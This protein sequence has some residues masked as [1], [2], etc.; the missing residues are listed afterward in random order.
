MYASRSIVPQYLAPGT[1]IPFKMGTTAGRTEVLTNATPAEEAATIAPIKGMKVGYVGFGSQSSN[2]ARCLREE[3]V[4][5]VVIGRDPASPSMRAAAANGFKVVGMQDLPGLRL[6]I[7]C[8]GLP[9][10]QQVRELPAIL[11]CLPNKPV[12]LFFHGMTVHYGALG[13]YGSNIQNALL[14]WNIGGVMPKGPGNT[15]WLNKQAGGGIAVLIA[16]FEG[17]PDPD[18]VRTVVKAYSA[19]LGGLRGATLWTT[20]KEETETDHFGEQGVL[21]GTLL[22]ACMFMV[23]RTQEV[24]GLHFEEAVALV[25]RELVQFGDMVRRGGA[26]YVI[27]NASLRV[28]ENMK[29]FAS[30]FFYKVAIAGRDLS[31][32]ELE[33][34]GARLRALQPHLSPVAPDG[35]QV[36]GEVL[37]APA[38]FDSLFM[39]G[40]SGIL[41]AASTWQY[42]IGRRAGYTAEGL[43]FEV[44]QEISLITD[45]VR[46]GGL[47]YMALRIS[48]TAK[49]GMFVAGRYIADSVGMPLHERF[50]TLLGAIQN[51]D[52]AKRTKTDLVDVRRGGDGDWLWSATKALIESP[53]EAASAARRPPECADFK[54]AKRTS[55]FVALGDRPWEYHFHDKSGKAIAA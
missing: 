50:G 42:C 30:E 38:P 8:F 53:G 4:D 22:E 16:V 45:C 44:Q 10:D 39:G 55:V 3:G 29:R 24:F 40:I 17:S 21:C 14:G 13:Y 36:C 1:R 28:F 7:L 6:D 34:V 2:H 46:L 32:D 35:R 27:R 49:H 26:S 54:G 31:D 52:Y 12:L 43:Q 19:A 48:T 25:E 47:S 51:G 5:V 41:L 33:K 15:V 11:A 9:D 23:R 18:H 37:A 20:F